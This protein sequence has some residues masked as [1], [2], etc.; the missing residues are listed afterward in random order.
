MFLGIIQRL[1]HIINNVVD[2]LDWG[3]YPNFVQQKLTFLK[4]YFGYTQ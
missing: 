2:F 4:I 1:Y 3:H